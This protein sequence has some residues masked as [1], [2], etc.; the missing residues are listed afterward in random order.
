[1][2]TR[3]ILDAVSGDA[4]NGDAVKPR[5]RGEMAGRFS[6]GG[7]RPEEGAFFASGPLLV[8]WGYADR[9]CAAGSAFPPAGAHAPDCRAIAHPPESYPAYGEGPK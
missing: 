6:G 4:A 7:R 8:F 1:M 3:R 2:G 9:P 5:L